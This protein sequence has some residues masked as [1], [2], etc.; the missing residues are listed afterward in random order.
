MTD[1]RPISVPSDFVPATRTRTSPVAAEVAPRPAGPSSHHFGSWLESYFLGDH[2][3]IREVRAKVVRAAREDR[4]VLL[5]GETGT[6]KDMLAQAIHLGSARAGQVPQV[7]A[8]AG[9][10]DTAWSVVF[11]HRKG[12]FT[13]ADT[14]HSGVFKV[15]DGSTLILEDVA[16]VPLSVQPMLLRAIEHGVFRPLGSERETR[17]DVRIVST[18][19]LALDREVS[20]GRFRGDL[21]QRL[22]VLKI[23]IPPLRDH[24]EDLELYASHFLAKAATVH[25]PPKRLSRAALRLLGQYPWPRNIR[26]L[27]HLLYHVSVDTEMEEIVPSDLERIWK[28]ESGFSPTGLLG[29]RPQPSR[30]LA[31]ASIVQ[32][33]EDSRGNKRAAAKSLNIS[34]GTLYSLMK[35]HRIFG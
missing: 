23:T 14:D 20:L 25:R 29:R 5:T 9:L 7:V 26:E 27:E 17:T 1:L 6:G 30:V 19:N 33:L 12:S 18:S 16:E 4:P 28:T 10:G 3:L 21:Y 2:V 22:S 11:G 13:G 8:V 31:R 35:R 32:A 24:L 34:P 15:A